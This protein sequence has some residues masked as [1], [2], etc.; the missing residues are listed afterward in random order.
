M[1]R[2]MRLA[3][4]SGVLTLPGALWASDLPSPSSAYLSLI[5]EYRP[6]ISQGRWGPARLKER[7]S[8]TKKTIRGNKAFAYLRDYV[9]VATHEFKEELG[10]LQVKGIHPDIETRRELSRFA[11]SAFSAIVKDTEATEKTRRELIQILGT[12]GDD[13]IAQPPK[14]LGVDGIPVSP[15]LLQVYDFAPQPPIGMLAVAA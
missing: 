11:I 9:F 13:E 7:Y 12:F 15:W 4:A 10:A 3:F 6:A 2:E 14:P 5:N 8:T 1:M